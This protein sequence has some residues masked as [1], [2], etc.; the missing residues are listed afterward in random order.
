M[1]QE[2]A[3]VPQ[4]IIQR[5]NKIQENIL[6]VL[7]GV[8][9]LSLLAQIAI[10]LPWTPVPI[11]GQTFGVALLALLWG[12]KR[13]MAA[14]VSYVT[15]GG[16]GL[17]IFALGKSGFALGPTSGYLFGMMIA[18]YVM[19]TLSDRGSTKTWLRSYVTALCGSVII[20][21]CG[22]LWLSMFLP[23]KELLSAGLLPFLP[24]DLLKTLLAS[25]IAF[26]SGKSITKSS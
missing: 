14:I 23:T 20:F 21:T 12:R 19:G 9:G 8:C 26:Q 2:L 15:L 7:L 6:S 5:G 22:I 18:T 3:L 13:A 10:P 4:F 11:T 25:F 24:G 16:L 17:P 1:T